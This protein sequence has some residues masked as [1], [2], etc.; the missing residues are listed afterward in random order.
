M[1]IINMRLVILTQ[2]MR[3]HHVLLNNELSL[4]LQGGRK[5]FISSWRLDLQDGKH[6]S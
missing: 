2:A 5:W 4:C 3:V 6:C 1:F